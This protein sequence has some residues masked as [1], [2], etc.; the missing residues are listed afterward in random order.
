[1]IA[2]ETPLHAT[3]GIPT[4]LSRLDHNLQIN[5]MLRVFEEY[6]A[7]CTLHTAHCSPCRSAQYSLRC[8]APIQYHAST[9]SSG[10]QT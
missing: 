10:P 2:Q 4:R 3:I 9:Q 8:L 5:L 7:H 6:T 1:M